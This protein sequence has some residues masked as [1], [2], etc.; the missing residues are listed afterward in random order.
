PD[1]ADGVVHREGR[2]FALAGPAPEPGAVRRP[3]RDSGWLLNPLGPALLG[4]DPL[5]PDLFG[6]GP[7][8]LDGVRPEG[9][10]PTVLRLRRVGLERVRL[11][12]LRRSVGRNGLW[13][14]LLGLAGL[15]AG[16][17]L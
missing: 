6:L 7:L 13:P 15:L 1:A 14:G 8:G 9:P 16:G 2:L 4:L 12:R 5:G 11:R 3:D 17:L 10:R